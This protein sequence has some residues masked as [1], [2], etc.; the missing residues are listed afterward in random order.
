MKKP[1][2]T[3]LA[4]LFCFQ[5]TPV[6]CAKPETRR[7][8]VLFWWNVENLFDTRND[9][10]TADDEF[11]PEGRMHWTEKK[12][13]L[14]R[15][16]IGHVLKAVRADPAIRKYP[17]I[18]AFAETENR[19]VFENTLACADGA[20]YRTLYYE[21]RDPRGIDIGVAW[22]PASV[23][24][25][26]SKACS[27]PGQTRSRDIIVAGFSASD[28]PF[29]IIFNHWPSR[30]FDAEWSEPRRMAAAKVARRIV[31]SLLSKNPKAE[32]IVMGDFNDQPDNRSM[33]MV[34]G[35][36]L[37]RELVRKKERHLLYNCWG[38]TNEEGSYA[39]R[40]RWERIDHILVSAALLDGKVLSVPKN[41]FRTFSF[42]HMMAVP[43]KKPYATYDKGK[44]RGGYSDHLPLIL[45]VDVK[46]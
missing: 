1:F 13:A 45:K 5:G 41:A 18:L 23:K 7:N 30:S 28:H 37:D 22:N 15:I 33:Q 39:Y 3:L 25:V 46:K 27:I 4:L 36:S 43:G 14:K 44:Y 20:M 21:S 19:Q 34:L 11:T 10:A 12:L 26:S 24:L 6:T 32:I 40:G 16:R 42:P 9:P 8:L 29:H 38:D 2:A 31:D 35:S 17:D